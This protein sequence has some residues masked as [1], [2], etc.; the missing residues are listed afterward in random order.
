[1]TNPAEI[2]FRTLSLIARESPGQGTVEPA[3]PNLSL[4]TLGFDSMDLIALACSLEDEFKV[5]LPTDA[6]VEWRI[7]ADV[8]ADIER[9]HA[10]ARYFPRQGR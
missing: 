8:I 1:M 10:H 9:A 7:I 2:R 3:A 6:D 4:E 5:S